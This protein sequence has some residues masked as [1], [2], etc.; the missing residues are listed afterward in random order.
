M[1]SRWRSRVPHI[2]E[3]MP[4]D[5]DIV[6]N[7]GKKTMKLNVSNTGDRPIQVGS[8]THFS[9]AN[10]ALEFDREKTLGFH[11]N[12]A[13]GTSIRFEPGE[14]KHVEVVE[15]GGTKTIFGFSGLVLSLI[16]I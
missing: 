5:E 8:H 11:L 1:I 2:G 16:H 4:K 6:A 7:D 15:F 10:K 12:I 14:S 13:S 3:Y 9:E